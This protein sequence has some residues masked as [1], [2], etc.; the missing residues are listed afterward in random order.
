ML[1]TRVILTCMVR[2]IGKVADMGDVGLGGLGELIGE[3]EGVEGDVATH[4]VLVEIFHYVGELFDSE[5]GGAV[6]GVEIA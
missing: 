3:D 4:V 6:S 1:R 2:I 5:I